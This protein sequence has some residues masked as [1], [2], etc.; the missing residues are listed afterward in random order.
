MMYFPTLKKNAPSP[1]AVIRPSVPSCV[2]VPV[3]RSTVTPELIVPVTDRPG[4]GVVERVGTANV[5]D[6]AGHVAIAVEEQRAVEHDRE[7]IAQVEG[8]AVGKE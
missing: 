1:G 4:H 8:A 3:A 2:T 6:D 7:A 5:L